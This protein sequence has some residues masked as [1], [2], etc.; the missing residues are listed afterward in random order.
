MKQPYWDVDSQIAA[1]YISDF[2]RTQMTDGPGTGEM[3]LAIVTGLVEGFVEGI[4]QDIKESNDYGTG[5][6]GQPIRGGTPPV[7]GGNGLRQFFK[8]AR[9]INWKGV[10]QFGHTFSEHGEKRPVQSL[11]DRARSTGTPQ[12]QWLDN[13]AAADFLAP[14]D[15]LLQ[16]PASVKLPPG[17]GQIV[18]PD[19]T[20]TAATRAILIPKPGGGFRTA[21]PIP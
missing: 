11:I 13:S 9:K 20:I 21:F 2:L 7:P 17:L 6:D 15:G 19:G 4:I 3:A 18:N 10:K 14:F 5:P 8:N 1:P 16:G 12:G